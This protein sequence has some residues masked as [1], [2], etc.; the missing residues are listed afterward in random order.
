MTSLTTVVVMIPLFVMTT[1]A[2]RE[3]VLPLMVGIS[4][5]TLSSIFVCSPLYYELNNFG[6]KSKYQRMVEK[7]LNKKTNEEAPSEQ[8][9]DLPL[10]E[11]KETLAEKSNKK[12]LSKTQKQHKNAKK[13]RR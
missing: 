2:I 7:N 11:E 8:K 12:P 10:K 4:V 13:H 9:E 6:K 5:G 3:F 1:S